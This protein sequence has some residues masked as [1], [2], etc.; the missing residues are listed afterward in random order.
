[1]KAV[2]KQPVHCTPRMLSKRLKFRI[3]GPLHYH[4]SYGTHSPSTR[5]LPKWASNLDEA[6]KTTETC[7]TTTHLSLVFHLSSKFDI[8]LVTTKFV[9][10]RE[11]RKKNTKERI[12]R[13]SNATCTST[14]SKLKR[15]KVHANESEER[16]ECTRRYRESVDRDPRSKYGRVSF[17]ND[18]VYLGAMVHERDPGR[19]SAICESTR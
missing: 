15:L 2:P 12:E 4:A 13:E 3:S 9:T 7:S 10:Q 14:M 11:K 19:S 6:F 16:K 18:F 17:I 8:D 5:Y 1:M